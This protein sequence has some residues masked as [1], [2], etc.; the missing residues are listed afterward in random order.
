VELKWQSFSGCPENPPTII[1][2]MFLCVFISMFAS[3][4]GMT[5]IVKD[6]NIY[7]P[8]ANLHKCFTGTNTEQ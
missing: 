5:T 3:E 6:M 7:I 4:D 8:Y 1:S 2:S